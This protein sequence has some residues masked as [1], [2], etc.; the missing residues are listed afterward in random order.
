MVS[1][2]LARCAQVH[3]VALSHHTTPFD[4]SIQVGAKALGLHLVHSGA[5]IVDA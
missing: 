1:T 5:S 2:S 4:P 3:Q